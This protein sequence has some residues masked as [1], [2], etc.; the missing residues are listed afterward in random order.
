VNKN[1]FLNKNKFVNK[2]KLVVILRTD[3]VRMN[4]SQG[5]EGV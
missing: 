2:S 3:K 4:V 5:G 1:K